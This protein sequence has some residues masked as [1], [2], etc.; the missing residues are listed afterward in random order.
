MS[1]I[2]SQAYQLSTMMVWQYVYAEQTFTHRSYSTE[3]L[4]GTYPNCVT[5]TLIT[6]R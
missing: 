2:W 1:R 4:L 5:H 6:V 3:E